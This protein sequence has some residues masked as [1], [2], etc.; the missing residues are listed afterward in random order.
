VEGTYA[1]LLATLGNKHGA[2]ESLTDKAVYDQLRRLFKTHGK[3]P[4]YTPNRHEVLRVLAAVIGKVLDEVDEAAV[5]VSATPAVESSS[6]ASGPSGRGAHLR[7]STTVAEV[8]T[9][10]TGMVD[11]ILKGAVGQISR[12]KVTVEAVRVPPAADVGASDPDLGSTT[13]TAD[14]EFG[15]AALSDDAF[16]VLALLMEYLHDNMVTA[17]AEQYKL[18]PRIPVTEQD[19][20]DYC[21]ARLEKSKF[22]SLLLMLARGKDPAQ[23]QSGSERTAE[24]FNKVL[25]V[26]IQELLMR[27]V[28]LADELLESLA[29]GEATRS[30]RAGAGTVFTPG[31]STSVCP[32][33]KST[34]FSG[35]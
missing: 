30:A 5:A 28:K 20:L 11:S 12:M 3:E 17:E 19:L 23:V 26:M 1:D 2:P 22:A 13:A 35:L 27:G 24:R 25:P 33:T 21:Q 15:D 4:T 31:F 18:P 14:F 16:E 32:C 10:A 7:K 8:K 9:V 34:R 6:T 29:T